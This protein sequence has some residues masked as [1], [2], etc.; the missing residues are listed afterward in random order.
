MIKFFR[1]YRNDILSTR[2]QMSS[3]HLIEIPSQGGYYY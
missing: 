1:H 2:D 3:G